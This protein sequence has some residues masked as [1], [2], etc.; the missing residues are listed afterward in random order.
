D[1][2]AGRD[3][4]SDQPL[5]CLLHLLRVGAPGGRDPRAV[6]LSHLVRGLGAERCGALAETSGDGVVGQGVLPAWRPMLAR[7]D[8]QLWQKRHAALNLRYD[9]PPPEGACVISGSCGAC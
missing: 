1:A 6:L 4:E 7:V 8:A 9:E 3:P 5:G 2:V